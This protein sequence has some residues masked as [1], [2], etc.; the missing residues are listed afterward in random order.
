MKAA[1]DDE[2]HRHRHRLNLI[3]KCRDV[4]PKRPII[5]PGSTVTMGGSFKTS[6]NSGFASETKTR[7]IRDQNDEG[8]RSRF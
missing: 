6:R 3:V 4:T 8:F 5:S 7:I 2:Q 1:H